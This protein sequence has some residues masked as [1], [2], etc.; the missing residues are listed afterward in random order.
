MGVEGWGQNAPQT[1][2]EHIKKR[3]PELGLEQ[4]KVAEK[5]E[6]YMAQ[7]EQRGARRLPP[8]QEGHASDHCVPR[9][10]SA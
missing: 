1:M 8:N 10:R 6:R 7:R 3:R 4:D 9:L 5:N 2:G